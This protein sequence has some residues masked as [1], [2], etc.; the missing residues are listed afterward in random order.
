M[1]VK[2]VGRLKG[3]PRAVGILRSEMA[4]GGTTAAAAAKSKLVTRMEVPEAGFLYEIEHADD[5]S[6]FSTTVTVAEND[7]TFT[8]TVKSPCCR[9]RE[10]PFFV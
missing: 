7:F 3:G 8:G 2:P 6:P 4:L 1:R 5:Y 10:P 9:R